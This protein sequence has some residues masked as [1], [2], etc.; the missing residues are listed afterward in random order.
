MEIKL[1]EVPKEKKPLYVSVYHKLYELIMDGT[2]P[3]E[4]KLPTEPELAKM[5]GVSRMTLRQA[6][7]LLQDD[8]LVSS[9]H[10]KGNFITRSSSVQKEDGLE[11]LG[12]PVYKCHKG[13][14]D[15]VEIYCRLEL[16]SE[17]TEQVLNRKAT[18]VVAIDRWYK[19][20]D[21]AVAY[22]FT[23]M[24]IETASE[25]NIDLKDEQL[26]L[27]ILEKEIYEKASSATIEIKHSDYMNVSSS[28]YKYT[29]EDGEICDLLLESVYMNEQQ[30]VVYNKFY[31][32]KV[33][34]SL[35]INAGR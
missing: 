5:L 31:I 13:I 21:K 19:Q 28:K 6:L 1:S 14:I 9:I 4:S 34:S 18:A 16:P 3:S 30:P 22:A 7:A 17:Y 15:T 27:E 33:Y 8:G 10:G 32:P 25:L 20:K 26:L 29:L 11:K 2:F 23:F 24:A 12:N 35:K